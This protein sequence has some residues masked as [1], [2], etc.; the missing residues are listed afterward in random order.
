M[1]SKT[2]AFEF[3]VVLKDCAWNNKIALSVLDWYNGFAKDFVDEYPNMNLEYIGDNIYRGSYTIPSY[4]T[5]S[6][7][8]QFEL[9]SFVDP[10]DDGNYPI[11]GHL[12]IGSLL[13]VRHLN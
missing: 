13:S 1:E 10:D 2:V 7:D 3:S 11:D 12:V 5:S 6:Y 8:P 4:A 9:E